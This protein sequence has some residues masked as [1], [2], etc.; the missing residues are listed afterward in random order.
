MSDIPDFTEKVYFVKEILNNKITNTKYRYDKSKSEMDKVEYEKL[1]EDMRRVNYLDAKTIRKY[2]SKIG[3]KK[4]YDFCIGIFDNLNQQI[5]EKIE[6]EASNAEIYGVGVYSNNIVEDIFCTYPQNDVEN[7][8][9]KV[10]NIKGIDFVFAINTNE[11]N[12]IK[13]IIQNEFSNY[14]NKK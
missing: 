1:L 12:K 10:K 5:I 7:R 2:S 6:E 11:E 9:K 13:E 14:L 4:K 8:M 3:K